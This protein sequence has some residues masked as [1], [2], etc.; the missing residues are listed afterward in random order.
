MVRSA[1]LFSTRPL[2]ELIQNKVNRAAELHTRPVVSN[3]IARK[4]LGTHLST[5]H[6][7]EE[8]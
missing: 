2:C 8:A 1:R 5:L 4:S 6:T 7:S 3:F